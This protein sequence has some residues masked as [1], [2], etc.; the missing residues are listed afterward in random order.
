MALKKVLY[1]RHCSPIY[2]E[3]EL[4]LYKIT[5]I[6]SQG[7]LFENAGELRIIILRGKKVRI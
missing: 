3:D 6:A 4:P 1:T 7:F 5:I 2:K